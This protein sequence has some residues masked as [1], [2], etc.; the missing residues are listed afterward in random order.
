MAKA[1]RVGLF[2][3]QIIERV[4]LAG[5]DALLANASRLSEGDIAPDGHFYGSTMITFD[6]RQISGQLREAVD[7][8]TARRLA[9]LMNED[10]V[11]KR[12]LKQLATDEALRVAEQPLDRLEVDVR[13]RSEG[14]WVFIDIDT[15]GHAATTRGNWSKS[16]ASTAS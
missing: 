14:C 5:V 11:V 4:S 13:V 3:R 12:R 1:Q 2:S 15:E 16:A 9:D 7:L 6:L 8:K 10:A